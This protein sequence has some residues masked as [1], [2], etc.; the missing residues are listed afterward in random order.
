MKATMKDVAALAGVGLGSVSRV[1]NGVR[2]KEST[3]KKVY[4]AIRELNYEPDEY[5][6]GLKTNRSNT[7]ALIIPTIWH[8]FFSE[9]AYFVEEALSQRNY[10]LLLCNSDGNVEKEKEYIQMVKQSKVD[11]IIGITYS[12]VDKYVS[13]NLPFVSIDRHFSEEVAYV[14]ADNY[15]GGQIAAQELIKR[16]CQ[17]VAYVGGTS[18]YP[19]E[20]NNRKLGFYDEC[21]KHRLTPTILDMPE[22]LQNL[23]EQ[24][25][26]FFTSNPTIDGIFTVNDFMGL[27]VIKALAKLNKHPV[28]DYQLIGFDGVKMAIDQPLVL[29]TIVQPVIEMAY[30]SVETILAMILNEPFEQRK[31]LDVT[32]YEGGTTKKIDN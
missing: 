32:F 2:V 11:G 5:A 10:K 7:I 13:A 28:T 9:F 17:Q 26:A 25:L 19:N 31:L 12:D 18:P 24:L 16:E 30:N 14:T 6:R 8:P 21:L 22:P 4:D 23:D 15:R 27:N 29:S 20:T 3:R 1:I